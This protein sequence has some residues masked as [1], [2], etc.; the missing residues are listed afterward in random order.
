MKSVLVLAT[1]LFS[2]IAQAA[3]V[4]GDLVRYKMT[5][6]A[7]GQS[8]IMEQKMEVISID[9]NEG[10]YTTKVTVMMNGAVM[11]QTTE[12]SDLNSATES[13][14]TLDHCSEMPS[15]MASIET[16]TVPAGTFKVCHISTQQG[17]VKLDQFMGKVL[18]G[19][20][21][22]VTFDSNSNITTTYELIEVIKH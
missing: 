14:S 6:S 21:K 4:V 20:V 8:R 19:L 17:S 1:I 11:G 15:D 9:A 10:T 5:V 22:S 2:T 7:F 3:P 13:E 16:I 18:F 12:T